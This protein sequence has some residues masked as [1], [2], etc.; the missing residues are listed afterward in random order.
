MTIQKKK[1]KN[2]GNHQNIFN[3]H[4]I[5]KY[6][7]KNSF[8]I[9]VRSSRKSYFSMY[10]MALIV[11]GILF[12]LYL[13][14]YEINTLS[15]IVSGLFVL[16]CIKYVEYLVLSDWWAITNSSI[17]QSKGIF[18]KNVREVDFSSI[19]DLDIEQPFIKRIFGY[20]NVHIRLFLNE[21]CITVKEINNPERFMELLQK[22]ITKKRGNRL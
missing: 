8:L 4:S 18:N 12:Y 5:I 15:L 14:D 16:F 20:G 13:N 3:H 22:K 9:K 10:L 21:T 2:I 17:I 6:M 1:I 7:K 19:S 11:I